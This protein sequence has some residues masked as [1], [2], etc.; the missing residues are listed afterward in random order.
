MKCLAKTLELLF[1]NKK[2]GKIDLKLVYQSSK[3]QKAAASNQNNCMQS[4][5]VHHPCDLVI[6]SS[7]VWLRI[8]LNEIIYIGNDIL[9]S[10]TVLY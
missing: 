4:L 3:Y 8:L 2:V 7:K 6:V 9:I 10:E 5:A 1:R